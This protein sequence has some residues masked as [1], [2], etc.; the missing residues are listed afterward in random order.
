MKK[1]WGL[2]LIALAAVAA[3]FLPGLKLYVHSQLGEETAALFPTAVTP[4]QMATR[5]AGCL[6]TDAVPALNVISFSGWMA[7]LAALLL[8]SSAILNLSDNRKLCG[9]GV[10]LAGAA[11]AL[12]TTFAI[13]VNN[14][15]A[16]LL[17]QLLFTAQAW[18]Y[19]PV[20]AAVVLIAYEALLLRGTKAERSKLSLSGQRPSVLSEGAWRRLMGAAAVLAALL[21]L[22]PVYSV[23]VPATLTEDPQDAA[24]ISG[25]RSLLA[26]ALGRDEMLNA[27]KAEGRFANVLSGDLGALA[28]FSGDETNIKGI[29]QIPQSSSTLAANPTLIAA[30]LL[31]ALAALLSFLPRVDKWFPTALAALAT[32]ALDAS[33][34][35]ALSI[36]DADMYTGAARQ[37]LHLGLGT[38]M[39]FAALSTV[40]AAL[41]LVCGALCIHTADAPYF[42][43]PN[44]KRS[45]IRVVA[46]ALAVL[47]LACALLPCARLSFYNPGKTKVGATET[48]TGLE[49]LGLRAPERIAHPVSSKGK[50]LYSDE[51]KE[52]V[53]N[54]GQVEDAMNRLTRTFGLLTWAVL[55]LTAAGI[56]TVLMARR[57]AAIALFLSAFVVRAL[58][59]IMLMTG[60]PGTL[61]TA[62]GTVYLYLSLPLLLFAAFFANNAPEETLP[63]KYKLFLMMLPFLV[64]VFL[65]AYQPLYGWSYAFFNYKFGIPLN[66]QEFVGLKWFT[67][68][69][70][71]AANRENIVRVLK[72]TFGMS[73]LNL[74]TSWMPM[75]FAVFLNEITNSRFKK[76]VQIFTTLPNFISW[77]LVFSFAMCLFAMDTGIFSKFMLGIGAIDEPVV[78]LNSSSHIWL[79]MWAWSTWKGLGWGAIMY[80]AAISGIPVELYEAAKVDGANRWH[81]MRYITLPSLLPT[82]FVLLMLSISN[83]LN[84]GM[85]QYLVFQNPMNKQSIEVL[86]L[87]VYNITIA[88]G[89]TTLH[90]FATAIGILKT[91]VSVTL[92]FSANFVSKKLRGESIV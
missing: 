88:S 28:P 52:G 80:L 9:V 23:R 54:A 2:L 85:E 68:M 40:A 75:I 30:A 57:K 13:H 86:D 78:W 38:V 37:T 47:A 51:E 69:F 10:A 82:F 67:E 87:Y 35:N 44:P 59:W 19:L 36:T 8:L 58:A 76:T 60:M 34:L 91:I 65:F 66:Q 21:M 56:V 70:T 48:L 42:V 49:A 3:L 46:V 16:S 12:S 39:P 71:N 18:I 11:L 1:K 43:N 45:Q 22:L 53:M 89:G 6:P 90:S 26:A 73:G 29:F 83:I 61:G 7:V 72:N 15:A 17:F 62:G 84:N 63:K 74:L 92:L 33:L 25:S 41:S 81:Q 50:T 77:A 27:L 24:A 79:K 64:A 55:I 20:G 31:L 14:L 5:G 4:W 32:V